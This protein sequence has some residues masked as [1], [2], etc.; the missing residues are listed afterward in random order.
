[1][2]LDNSRVCPVTK[3]VLAYPHNEKLAQNKGRGVQLPALVSK[4][5]REE[6][7]MVVH[8]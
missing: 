4:S 8:T 7:A 2:H 3:P 5:P 6:F 1:M